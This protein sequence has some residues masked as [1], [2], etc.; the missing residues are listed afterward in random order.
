MKYHFKTAQ[1]K[2]PAAPLPPSPQMNS[3]PTPCT[4]TRTPWSDRAQSTSPLLI[5]V[6]EALLPAGLGPRPSNCA[7][8][9][10]A[11]ETW[12]PDP[13]LR[14]GWIGP[15]VC[16][17]NT[18]TIPVMPCCSVTVGTVGRPLSGMHQSVTPPGPPHHCAL[19]SAWRF[20][21][22]E[23]LLWLPPLLCTDLPASAVAA[24][25]WV[26]SQLEEL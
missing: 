13:W 4:P 10:Q 15:A 19:F 21:V 25:V 8:V 18:A 16:R 20:T 14:V 23:L 12:R 9:S 22:L 2:P 7:S 3:S 26:T 1:L 17:W 24:T 5:T 6:K 11:Q